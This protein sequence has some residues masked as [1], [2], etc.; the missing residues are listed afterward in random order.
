MTR[1]FYINLPIGGVAALVIAFLIRVPTNVQSEKLSIKEKLRRLD[2]LGSICFLPGIVCLVLALQW[3]GS[4]YDWDNARVIALLVLSVLLLSAFVAIQFLMPETATVPPRILKQRSM[5]AAF[6]FVSFMAAAMLVFTYYLPIWFQA[7]KAASAVHS[8]IMVLPM[9]LSLVVGAIS[10]GATLSLIVGYFTPY[11]IACGILT[12]IGAGLITTFTTETGHA[13]W[14][15]FQVILGFGL[16]LG[17]QQPNM[18]AQTVLPKVDVPSG[19]AL[20][21]F[22]QQVG[23][24]IFIAV[25]QSVFTNRLSSILV[26][27][28]HIDPATIVKT[29]ATDFRR[30][31][32]SPREFSQ[33]LLAYNEAIVNAFRVGL[34]VACVVIIPALF[35]E[36]KSVRKEKKNTQRVRKEL[37]GEEK[38]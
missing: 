38:V 25:A 32:L 5:A 29:G 6:V 3:G 24:A 33:V 19:T 9:L 31:N 17:M 26:N 28:F 30:L 21:F 7:I 34:G 2:P 27:K 36:W 12:S 18:A 16:G 20:V 15:G 37:E 22:G 35:M 11:M 1:C 23:G 13:K 10:A 4:K 8:G 14:I